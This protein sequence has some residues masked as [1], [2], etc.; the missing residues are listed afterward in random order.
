VQGWFS[1]GD[2]R[3]AALGGFFGVLLGAL[4][5][6]LPLLDWLYPPGDKEKD[7]TD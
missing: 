4:N 6:H 2:W 5:Y 3:A 1:G 7:Q